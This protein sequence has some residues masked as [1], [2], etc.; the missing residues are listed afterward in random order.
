MRKDMEEQ[1][2]TRQDTKRLADGE[3]LLEAELLATVSHELRSP[4]TSIKGYTATLLRH[5]YQLSRE[6]RRE[7]L[8]AIQEASLRLEYVMNRLLEIGQFEL[9]TIRIE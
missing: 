3:K 1:R 7:F 4:L 9:G 8:T 2:E 6:E 5:E